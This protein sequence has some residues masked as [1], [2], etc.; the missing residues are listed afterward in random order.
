MCS[1]SLSGHE[2]LTPAN[3]L[4]Q[5]LK[6]QSV[7]EYFLYTGTINIGLR[8]W[9]EALDALE[10]V[11]TYPVKENAVSLIMV[12]AYK[13]WTL[14]NVLVNGKAASLPTTTNNSAAKLYHTLAKPYE[15][16]AS[17]F[18]TAIAPR[19]NAEI[20][21]GQAIWRDDGNTGLMLCILSAYQE[22]QIRHLARIYRTVSISDVTQ[23]TF[24]AESGERLPNDQATESLIV[25]M[26]SRK[27]LHASITHPVDSA[28]MLSFKTADPILSELDFERQLQISLRGIKTMAEGIKTTD[29]RLTFDKEYLKW[30]HKQKTG[31]NAAEEMGNGVSDEDLMAF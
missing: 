30:A 31:G 4:T 17:L 22:F 18:E 12:E 3:G 5:K 14:V 11:V 27:V 19:L 9:Q 24:S 15:V 1:L 7:L 10:V 29:R 2:Y 26:I 6:Y 21:A 25:D 16:V 23:M 20:T 13:K 28:P 8:K